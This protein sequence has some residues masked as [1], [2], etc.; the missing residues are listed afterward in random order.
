MKIPDFSKHKGLNKLK[1]DM[2]IKDTEPDSSWRDDFC[3]KH[4]EGLPCMECQII[5]ANGEGAV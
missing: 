3:M 2:G 1:K 5:E 4:G